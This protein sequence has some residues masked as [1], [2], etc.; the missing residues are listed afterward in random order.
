MVQVEFYYWYCDGRVVWMSNLNST[1]GI[2]AQIG[3]SSNKNFNLLRQLFLSV[4]SDKEFCNG[5]KKKCTP[6]F[7][8]AEL[9]ELIISDG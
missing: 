1:I 5:N 4:A 6:N 7:H 3:N 8:A 9:L 2:K